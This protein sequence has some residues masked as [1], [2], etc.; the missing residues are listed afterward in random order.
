MASLQIVQSPGARRCQGAILPRRRGKKNKKTKR[1][2]QRKRKEIGKTGRLILDNNQMDFTFK[3]CQTGSRVS[4][5]ICS[6]RPGQC[7][8]LLPGT[9]SHLCRSQLQPAEPLG[10][11]PGTGQEGRL[12]GRAVRRGP[13]GDHAH[14]HITT[15]NG[16]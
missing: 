1:N 9:S 12:R 11:D 13:D 6:A 14:S 7:R 5:A 4:E 15:S 8:A 16:N 10:R 2:S 3:C